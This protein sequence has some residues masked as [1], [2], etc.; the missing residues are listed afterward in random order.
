[1][2]ENAP[3][4]PAAAPITNGPIPPGAARKEAALQRL[5]RLKSGIVV[6]TLLGFGALGVLVSG[7]RVGTTAPATPAVTATPAPPANDGGGAFGQGSSGD[8]GGGFFN[9]GGSGGQGG[10]GFGNGGNAQPPVAGSG[11]S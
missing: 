7:H 6:T 9:G 1:M 2:T 10:Y 5:S 8:N 3:P 4:R 11:A